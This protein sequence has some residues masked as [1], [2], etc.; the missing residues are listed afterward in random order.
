[1][2]KTSVSP[3][4]EPGSVSLLIWSVAVVGLLLHWEVMAS[5]VLVGSVCNLHLS[6]VLIMLELP[7][8]C[9]NWYWRMHGAH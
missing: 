5:L 8:K 7:L 2:P 3:R 4:L 6:H 1:M 9:S